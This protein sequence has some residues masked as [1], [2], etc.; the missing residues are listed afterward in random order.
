LK[1]KKKRRKGCRVAE[2]SRITRQFF[3]V[4]PRMGSAEKEREGE[5]KSSKGRRKKEKRREAG[6]G[7][8]TANIDRRT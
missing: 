4:F 8:I 6:M 1:K 7:L 5:E 3:A 2:T